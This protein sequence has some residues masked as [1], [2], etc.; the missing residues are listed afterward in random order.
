MGTNDDDVL[1]LDVEQVRQFAQDRMM[2]CGLHEYAQLELIDERCVDNEV[3]VFTPLT[4]MYHIDD[5][6]KRRLLRHLGPLFTIY[7]DADWSVLRATRVYIEA[8]APRGDTADALQ[9]QYNKLRQHA[10]AVTLPPTA[11]H[12]LL[13]IVAL[14]T[15][16]LVGDAVVSLWSHRAPHET[17]WPLARHYAT[18]WWSTQ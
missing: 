2:E 18:Q 4:H 17:L 11:T 1:Q 10:Y 5:D 9:R 3:L 12:I 7:V 13:L 6:D 16:Y 14:Y 8:H 15:V